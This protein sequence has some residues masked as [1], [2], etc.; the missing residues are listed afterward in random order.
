MFSHQVIYG[1]LVCLCLQLL[2]HNCF[3][4]RIIYLLITMLI[5]ASFVQQRFRKGELVPGWLVIRCVQ[6]LL[7]IRWRFWW[8]HFEVKAFFLI[9][10][11]KLLP[12]LFNLLD[13]LLVLSLQSFS[14]ITS[15]LDFIELPVHF[16]KSFGVGSNV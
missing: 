10:L 6:L 1:R 12:D 4:L 5:L 3:V 9:A 7:V 15:I 16:L 14:H 11:L 13:F 8:A 2:Y